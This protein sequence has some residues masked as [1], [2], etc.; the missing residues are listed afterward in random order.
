MADK[1]YKNLLD[2]GYTTYHEDGSVSKTYKNLLDDGTTTYHED[3]STS[4]TYSHLLD[5]GYTTYHSDGSRSETYRNLLDDGYT[6]YHS[7]GGTSS[8]YSNL[9]DG[10]ST[11]HSG[12]AL[13]T[14]GYLSYGREGSD[15]SAFDHSYSAPIIIDYRYRSYWTYAT[16]SPGKIL[17]L[18]LLYGASMYFYCGAFS[19]FL[20]LVYAVYMAVLA[21]VISSY[22]KKTT[23]ERESIT[24]AESLIREL[25]EWGNLHAALIPIWL[26]YTG[27][28]IHFQDLE[29]LILSLCVFAAPICIV[30]LG[31]EFRTRKVFYAASTVLPVILFYL[32]LRG[33]RNAHDVILVVYSVLLLITIIVTMIKSLKV[34]KILSIPATIIT[35][36]AV[37]VLW[38]EFPAALHTFLTYL[39]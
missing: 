5:D 34:N 33:S 25:A 32:T 35:M 12:G 16:L 4:K 14:S 36:E 23:K 27:R 39:R 8:T 3:G 11:Y 28:E 26:L 1:T 30:I 10:Y 22:N 31:V 38:N 13:S 19:C 21:G 37:F 29:M 7:N 24:K 18:V 6:T 15:F 17:F 2:D 20:S 9:L